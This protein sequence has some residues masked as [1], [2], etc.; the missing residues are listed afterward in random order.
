M[1]LYLVETVEVMQVSPEY[2]SVRHGQILPRDIPG[3]FT[4]DLLKLFLVFVFLH[5]VFT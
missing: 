4:D 5:L 1:R 2:S 3:E